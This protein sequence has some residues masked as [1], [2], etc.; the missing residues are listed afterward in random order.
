MLLEEIYKDARVVRSG[1]NLTTVNEFT[2]QIPA[3]RPA[4]L[5]EVAHEI[6]K[7]ANLDVSKIVT[8]EDK[9][10]ALATTVSL[11]TGVPLAIARWYSYSLG[12]INE[13]VVAIDS[14]YFRG[15]LYL[16]GVE[17][18]DRVIIIDDTLSS[19]GAVIALVDAVRGAGAEVVDIVCAVEKVGNSGAENVKGKTGLFVKTI[20]KVAVGEDRVTIV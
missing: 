5:M 2:D 9:G 18:G 11:L 1:E 4:V 13:Q 7:V 15:Q 6:I 12:G 3:L 20:M 8:E 16:N 10:A 19:G 17:A 14:E